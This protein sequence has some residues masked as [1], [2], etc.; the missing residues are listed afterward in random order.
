MK[1]KLLN[2]GESL[3]TYYLDRVAH[4]TLLGTY[5]R[6]LE[7]RKVVLLPEG[8]WEGKN[9]GEREAARDRIYAEDQILINLQTKLQDA[10]NNLLLTEANIQGL[11]A[12]RRSLEW[13]IRLMEATNE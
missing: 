1:D 10:Q 11:E 9:V 8:G 7:A 2:I 4:Q 3:M 5:S 13:V 6:A 12:V